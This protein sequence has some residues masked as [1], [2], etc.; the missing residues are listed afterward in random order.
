MSRLESVGVAALG[1]AV[2]FGVFTVLFATAP[3]WNG[4]VVMGGFATPGAPVARITVDRTTCRVGQSVVAA[5]EY[6]N[7]YLNNVTFASPNPVYVN[8]KQ[9]GEDNNVNTIV[10]IGWVTH[11]ITLEPGESFTIYSDAFTA[12]KPGN[13]TITI[14]GLTRTITVF[15]HT[16]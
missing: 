12:T 14:N 10:Q 11:S 4:D 7:P 13:M 9:A 5:Y 3:S 16:P 2:A 8:V 15:P 1:F 6:Y